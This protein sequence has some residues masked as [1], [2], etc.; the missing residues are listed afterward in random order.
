MLTWNGDISCCSLVHRSISRDIDHHSTP[1]TVHPG[2][3]LGHCK[4]A[5]D[6][7]GGVGD[8]GGL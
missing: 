6:I 7:G 8:P 2:E 1:I 4:C 3:R 5:G